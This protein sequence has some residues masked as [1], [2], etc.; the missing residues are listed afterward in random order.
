LDGGDE[1]KLALFLLGAALAQAQY[2]FEI[3]VY[4]YETM[5]RGEYT[6]E[7][8]L[9]YA[10][11][12]TKTAEAPLA[13]SNNQFHMTGE[14]TGGITDFAS[15]GFMFLGASRPGGGGPDYAGWRLL[16]HLYIPRSWHLPLDVG[17][18][19]EFSFQRT[20]YEEN[21]RRVELRPILEKKF[22][23]L[24]LDTNP[25]FERALHGPGVRDGWIF[26]PA[27]RAGFEASRRI[28]PSLEYYGSTGP[29]QI[30]QFFPGADIRISNKV[31][32]SAGVG[33]GATSS[34]SRLIYKSRIEISFGGKD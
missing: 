16:P 8:H 33:I 34:G 10:G 7:A 31:L 26:E 3:H 12:G 27:G 1:L 18:V 22:G 13:P 20:T 29:M 2:P 17:L 11:V 32:W 4:E 19:T 30:H 14:L 5:H 6:L 9:N 25:V 23:R 24:Q 15:L 21:S 28:T